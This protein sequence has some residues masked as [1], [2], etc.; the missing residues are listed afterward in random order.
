[1]L[2]G[3]MVL[4][5]AIEKVDMVKTS[6][7]LAELLPQWAKGQITLKEIKGY[8]DSELFAIARI[9]YF[10]L[11]QGRNEEARILFEGLVA[12]DPHNDYYYRALGVIFQKIGDSERAL[13]Q[14]SYAIRINP[15]SPHAYVNRAEIYLSLEQHAE[16][17]QDLRQ[18]LDHIS[19]QDQQLSQK[20]WALYR[21]VAATKKLAK[22]N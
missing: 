20:A 12:V 4:L 9:G 17:E 19:P 3:F 2:T 15:P 6:E 7:Q 13:R 22:N 18:A 5:H 16:A 11:M 10:F 8:A 1:M 21:V 14:Y